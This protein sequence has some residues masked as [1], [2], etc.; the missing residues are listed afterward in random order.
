MKKERRRRNDCEGTR[1]TRTPC[2]SKREN[3]RVEEKNASD[4]RRSTCANNKM[5]GLNL[6]LTIG[7]CEKN[8]SKSVRLRNGAQGISNRKMLEFEKCKKREKERDLAFVD[9]MLAGCEEFVDGFG[10]GE[11][12]EGEAAGDAGVGV[13]LDR[14]ALDLAKFAEMVT[15]IILSCVSGEA[16]DEKFA[17]VVPAGD[18]GGGLRLLLLLALLLLLVLILLLL[19]ARRLIAVLRLVLITVDRRHCVGLSSRRTCGAPGSNLCITARLRDANNT[20]LLR[21]LSKLPT[22]VA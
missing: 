3:S 17:L 11:D 19:L 1:E 6:R 18:A 9:V 20:A 16:A 22:Q 15:Q 13:H 10:V 7:K 5:S 4:H 2:V 21:E 14:D 8:D 12:H